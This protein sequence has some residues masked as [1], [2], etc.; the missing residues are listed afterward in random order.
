M[1]LFAFPGQRLGLASRVS[2]AEHH[3]LSNGSLL[4]LIQRF[5]CHTFVSKGG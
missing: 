5:I 4:A 3:P 1:G 2:C